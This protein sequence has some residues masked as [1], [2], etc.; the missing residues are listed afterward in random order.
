MGNAQRHR[1]QQSDDAKNF[2]PDTLPALRRAVADFSWL[3]SQG[4]SDGSATLS[5]VG[6]RYRLTARQR[7]A[8]M[9]AACSDQALALR[10]EKEVAP[11]QL[12]GQAIAIDG[13]NFLIT[14]ESGLSGGIVL[15]CR[16][17]AWR[18]V[19]SIHG[20]YRQVEETVPA[21]RHIATGLNACGVT[22]VTWF[23]DAPVSNSGRLRQLLLASAREGRWVSLAPIA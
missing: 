1:G 8:V 16:D 14:V 9:R 20:T 2:H 21:I 18:D 22:A 12:S 3:L 5:L 11:D 4:Y 13:Y 7:Q 19:A 17:S 6:D 10:K 15:E 23:L